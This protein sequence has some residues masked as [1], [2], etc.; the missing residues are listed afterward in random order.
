MASV[1]AS[2]IP[3]IQQFMG[4]FWNTIK[5]FYGVE[6]TDEYSA[7]VTDC[8]D[9]MCRDFPHP[10]CRKLILSLHDYIGNEQNRM[11]AELRKE[12]ANEQH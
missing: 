10:L 12:T 2:D 6:I 3:E 1:N 4:V 11:Q 7:E 8:L 9:Q 5:K